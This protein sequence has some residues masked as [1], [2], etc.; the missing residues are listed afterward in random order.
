VNLGLDHEKIASGLL[1][2][3]FG[4]C[5]RLTRRRGNNSRLYGD[6]KAFKNLLPLIFV[7]FHVIVLRVRGIARKLRRALSSC[8]QHG[9]QSH[10]FV[11]FLA[12]RVEWAS[13]RTFR[14]GTT[15]AV[16]RFDFYIVRKFLGGYVILLAG[17]VLIF[18]VL[19][20]VEYMDDFQEKGA[21]WSEV[22]LVYYPNYVPEIIRLVS[23]LALFLSAVYLTGRLAQKLELSTLQTSGVSLYRLLVPYTFVGLAIVGLMFWFNGY[24]VPHTNRVVVEFELNY[25]KDSR[26]LEYNNINRQ[27]RPGS[28]LSVGYFNR[29][30]NAGQ[31]ISLL[32]FDEEKHLV[33]RIEAD[34]MVWNDS[35]RVWAL[36]RPIVRKFAPD[37]TERYR[38]VQTIDTTLSILPRDLARTEGDMNAMTI[39]EGR[40]YL[41]ELRRSGADQIGLPRV[42]YYGKFSYPLANLILVLL[43]VPLASVRRRGGQTFLL[44]SGLFT[45]F[46]YLAVMK[47]IEPFGYSGE[48]PPLAA[49]WL[50]HAVFFAL[51]LLV[52]FRVRK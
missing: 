25:T 51:A 45:A 23:P 36:V 33:E 46:V 17:L 18:V 49:A 47:I 19:H 52:V 40:D 43:G 35:L 8:R 1:F 3:F 41:D 28:I 34:R 50:P 13:L 14:H 9:A 42:Q 2:Q 6:A 32:R 37:G 38:S 10:F 39:D 30:E 26:V 48:I 4:R 12:R 29:E 22:F 20:F 16:T 27:N 21:T 31:T 5:L 24:V 44:A 15:P 11:V 7:D